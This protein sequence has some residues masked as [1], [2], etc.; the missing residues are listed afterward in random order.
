M[1]H[2]G[3]AD[4]SDKQHGRNQWIMSS[5]PTTA[6]AG[7]PALAYLSVRY[8]RAMRMSWSGSMATPFPNG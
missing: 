8:L 6:G 5:N 2:A 4:S 1:E 3:K 7:A